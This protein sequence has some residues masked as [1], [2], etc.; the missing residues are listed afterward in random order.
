M[1]ERKSFEISE[2]KEKIF[3]RDRYMCKWCYENIMRFGT[4][5]LAH[6]ISQTKANIKKYGEDIIHSE[7]NIKSACCLR[8]NAK[9]AVGT[10]REEK[11]AKRIRKVIN[12][13]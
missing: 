12:E 6:G 5:Q 7:H 8:C 3:T 2:M 1:T 11:E 9:L 10:T 4:P 13:N